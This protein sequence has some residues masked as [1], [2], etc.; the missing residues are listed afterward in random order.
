MTP[1]FKTSPPPLI[2]MQERKVV[3]T[4]TIGDMERIVNEMHANGWRLDGD[5]T[6]S[7][8]GDPPHEVYAQPMVK[9]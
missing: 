4:E 8:E 5:M 3:R 7:N 9:G 2:I 6:T 1:A